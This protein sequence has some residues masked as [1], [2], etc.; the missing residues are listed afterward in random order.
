MKRMA[1]S[2][3]ITKSLLVAGLLGTLAFSA[4]AVP[5]FDYH[6]SPFDVFTDGGGNP[7]AYFQDPGNW[8]SA[9]V[10]AVTN[11]AGQYIR[12]MLNQ[13]IGSHVP[14]VI[15]NNIDMYQLMIGTGSGGGGDVVI[16]NGA[17]VT[18]GLGLEGAPTQ[19]TG[20]GYPDGPSTLYIGPGCFLHTGDHIWIGNGNNA[21]DTAKL[22]IDGG[23]L[24]VNGQFGLGWNGFPGTT[25]YA[26]VEHGGL[27]KLNQWATPT[28][29]QGGSVGVLNIADN[30]SS[31]TINGNVT[32]YFAA[33]TNSQQLI[34]YGGLGKITWNYNP[35]GNLTTILAVAPPDLNTPIFSTEPATA[36]IVALGAPAALH[37]VVS[38]VA[39][40][41]AWMFN[42][43]A[44]ADGGGYS[45]TQTANLSIAS[46]NSTNIGNYSV[47]AT[48]T[49]FPTE[50]TL[51]TTASVNADS[52][53][54]YPVITV[55]GVNGNSYTVQ[56]TASLAPP[57]TWNTLATVTVGAAPQQVVDTGTPLSLTRFYQV[58]QASP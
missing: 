4:K 41:Y 1:K 52:F 23:T 43:A 27:L 5:E 2:F 13:S 34:A 29:G 44:L 3:A 45:G 38:N 51:S 12:V 25:N 17:Q 39:V 53:N 55:A 32:G 58:I 26:T 37:A 11:S 14:A 36:T 7:Y 28:L 31:V 50:F 48:N 15:T 47:I 21:N 22:T 30:S 9:Q 35:S 46:V 18:A 42:G 24:Q 10:P 54:L 40:H 33:L 57:V 56:W 20:L 6:W 19:W 16:T 49:S 8:D